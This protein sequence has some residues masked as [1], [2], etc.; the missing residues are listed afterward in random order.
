MHDG[1]L[2]KYLESSMGPALD[3]PLTLPAKRKNGFL[4]MVSISDNM[5]I[6]PKFRVDV[7]ILSTIH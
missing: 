1:W 3:V 2:K 7:G 5:I 6:T 4:F